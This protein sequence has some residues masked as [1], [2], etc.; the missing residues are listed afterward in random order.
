MGLEGPPYP[1]GRV[2]AVGDALPK[3]EISEPSKVGV[4]VGREA[5]AALLMVDWASERCGKAVK[6]GIRYTND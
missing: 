6:R 5:C 4:V 3:L 2:I 1:V